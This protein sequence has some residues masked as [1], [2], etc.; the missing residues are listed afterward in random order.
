MNNEEAGAKLAHQGAEA[1]K[2]N[3][4]EEVVA[5]VG[6]VARETVQKA[7]HALDE[8]ATRTR[9]AVGELANQAAEKLNREQ[10]CTRAGAG[11]RLRSPRPHQPALTVNG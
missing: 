3:S 5:K 7:E 9:N 1:A 11:A 4:T 6:H 2:P 10:W 8:A